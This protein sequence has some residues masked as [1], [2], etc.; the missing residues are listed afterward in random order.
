M[1][2][3]FPGLLLLIAL[4]GGCSSKETDQNGLT[5]WVH[6]GQPGERAVIT[7]Q[8]AR[9][10]AAHAGAALALTVVPEGGYNAQV[11]A[12]ALADELPCL[13]E[14]DGP[15]LYN[16]AWQGALRPLDDLLPE[17]VRADLLPSIIAQGTWNGRLYSVGAFDSG[18]GLWA[19]RSRLEAVGAR[20]PAGPADAWSAAE[21]TDLLERL[22]ADDADGAV[23]DLKLNYT[24]EWFTYAFSP[25]LQSAG[26]DLVT[27]TPPLHAKGVLDSPAAVAAL[28]QV[29][30]WI[31]AGRVDPNLDD[32]AFTDGRVA[33]S[34]VGHWEYPRYREAAGADLILLP[35]PDF[36]HG[37]RTGQGSWNWAITRGCKRPE[38]AAAFLRF[39]LEPEEV[40]RM[41]AANGA[42]PGT[43]SA[44][45]RSPDYRPGGP[46]HLYVQQLETSAVPR[47]RTPAYPVIT[48]AFQQAFQD[49]RNGLDVQEALGRAAAVIDQDLADN[50]GYEAAQ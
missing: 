24:G 28:T 18:L 23:L 47:P 6:S 41:S 16:Y 26:A 19:R 39:L 9:Y 29:Q 50:H 30:G 10:N 7:D 15:F 43:R 32:A 31:S 44:V 45:A 2:A 38:A 34:W 40:L 21:F 12:A 4:L 17:A 8:V 35:L 25:V 22:A 13:L 3:L 48:S 27:R 5:L 20:I 37:S 46:L 1:R 14:F 49:V 36:G 33:I 42:V 11:Q